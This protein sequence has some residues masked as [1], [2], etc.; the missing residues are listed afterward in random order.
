M[1]TT[2]PARAARIAAFLAS[3]R[4]SFA[5]RTVHQAATLPNALA[6]MSDEELVRLRDR[7]A[8][9]SGRH[10]ELRTAIVKHLAER[11]AHHVPLDDVA[12]I[13]RL[14][15]KL[16]DPGHP[17]NRHARHMTTLSLNGVRVTTVAGRGL[18]L[19]ADDHRRMA[20]AHRTIAGYLK[21]Q[22]QAERSHRHGVAAAWHRASAAKSPR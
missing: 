9:R 1:A 19:T 11:A 21:Q 3:A 18:G 12:A 17:L 22:G 16:R 7:L 4:R 14:A 8:G 5:Q 10:A 15:P 13:E 2:G 20:A 6:R